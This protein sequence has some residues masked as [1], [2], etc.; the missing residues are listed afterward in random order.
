S[1]ADHVPHSVCVVHR[2]GAKSAKFGVLAET[3]VSFALTIRDSLR[4]LRN[5]LDA[6]KPI[7]RVSNPSLRP[8][9]SILRP[10]RSLRPFFFSVA[11]SPR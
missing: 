2:E 11:A 1:F 7:G 10:L 6:P 3:F 5:F 8:P 9:D 4:G